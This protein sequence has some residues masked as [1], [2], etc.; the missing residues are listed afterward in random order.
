MIFF[1]FRID[2]SIS[3]WIFGDLPD[4]SDSSQDL[5]RFESILNPLK[6][7]QIRA[8]HWKSTKIGRNHQDIIDMRLWEQFLGVLGNFEEKT[9]FRF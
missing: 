6:S 7:T 4:V 2:F 9:F 3:T 5:S 1:M 8:N